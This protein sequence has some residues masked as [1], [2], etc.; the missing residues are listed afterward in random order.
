LGNHFWKNDVQNFDVCCV[1]GSMHGISASPFLH[2]DRLG[3]APFETA[4]P[5]KIEPEAVKLIEHRRA[6]TKTHTFCEN[7]FAF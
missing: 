7:V 3:E 4:M 5:V 1:G 2:L 6:Q